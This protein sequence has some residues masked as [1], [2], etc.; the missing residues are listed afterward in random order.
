MRD[1][2]GARAGATD[3]RRHDGGPGRAAR[4]LPLHA[5][6]HPRSL[7][8]EVP[9]LQQ[10]RRAAGLRWPAH[11]PGAGPRLRLDAA[12]RGV[13]R[14]RSA[15]RVADQQVAD[16]SA[17]RRS[18]GGEADEGGEVHVEAQEEAFPDVEHRAVL[19]RHE[20]R[21]AP[22]VREVGAHLESE[23][24]HIGAAA[25]GTLQPELA[26]QEAE[27]HRIGGAVVGEPGVGVDR[28]EGEAPHREGDFAAEH[29]TVVE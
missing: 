17:A 19:D 25:A 2:R 18:P 15:E 20:D 6:L 23:A 9:A 29:R 24:P 3:L 27:L 11:Q 16:D 10:L 4:D 14:A 12:D 28:R 13:G 7:P 21:G 8:G 26:G 5:A 22:G 1:R